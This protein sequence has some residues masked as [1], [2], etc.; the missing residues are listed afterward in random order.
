VVAAGAAVG[1]AVGITSQKNASFDANL[2]TFGPA[3][4]TVGF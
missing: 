1:I 3:S 4:V 2:G